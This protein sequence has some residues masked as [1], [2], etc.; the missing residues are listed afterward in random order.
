MQLRSADQQI[1]IQF[2]FNGFNYEIGTIQIITNNVEVLIL[3]MK[4]VRNC[5]RTELDR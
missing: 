1:D 2:S 5:I 3:K 4:F